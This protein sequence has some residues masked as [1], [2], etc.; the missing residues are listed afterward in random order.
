M[1]LTGGHYWQ[2]P[3]SW[4]G[5]ETAWCL[6]LITADGCSNHAMSPSGAQ[7]CMFVLPCTQM[8]PQPAYLGVVMTCVH[9]HG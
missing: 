2:K 7:L 9:T 6:M 8:L 5:G 4:Y 3:G 1:W